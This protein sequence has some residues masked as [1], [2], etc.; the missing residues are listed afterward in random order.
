MS[1]APDLASLENPGEF[2]ARH[3]GISA[4]DEAHML[5]VIGEAS[6]HAL[7]E[8][9]VPRSIA[10]SAAMQLP[11]ATT[12]AAALA[13]LKTI[14]GKNKVYRSFI[15][16]G[17]YG[18][19]T[20]GVILRNILENPAWYTAYTPY[21]AEIS[22][23]RMEALVNFQ[24]MVTDLTGMAIANASML[25]EATA[26]AEAMTLAKR[27]V[28][29]KGHTIV[30]AGDAHPQTIE[31]IQT[32]AKPLGLSV[33]LAN[34]SQ[35]W[36]DALAAD[37][38]FAVLAQYPSTSGRIDDLRADVQTVHGKQ[39]AFI[40]AADL[41]ALTL[42]VPPGEFDA[43]IAIG[44]TQRF[45]MPMGAGGPHAA[46]MACR[47]EFKRSL[48]GRLVGVSVDTHG[49]PAYRLALQTR[50]QHI[51]REKATSNICTA[52]VLPAVVASM[53]AVYHGPQGLKRIAQRVAAYTAV[54][55]RGLQQLGCTLTSASAFDTLTV[56]A[57]DAAQAQG[58]VAK[59]LA[60]GAN[61]KLSWHQYVS[62]SLDETSTREDIALLWSV[63]AKDGQTLPTFD[64]FEKGVEPLIPAALRRTSAFLTHPVF[65]M[66]HSETGMLRYLRQLS[67]K[68]LA[69]D[70]SMIP[71]GSCTMKLNATSEMIPITWPEFA[72]VHPFAPADQ[73]AGYAEL[74]AQL[75][76]WL[77][78]ITG[79]AGVSLQPNAGSQGEYAGL[80]AIRA[81][82]A[83]RGD[84]Q[85][86]VCLIPSSA[87]GTNPASAQMAGLKVVVTKC[88]E[89]GNVDLADLKAK[90]E[91]YSQQLA[92]VMITYPS[93]HG[94][95]ETQVKDLCAL[96]HQHGG[97]VYVDGANMNALVGVAA[98]GEFG[99]DVSHL[100]LHKTFCIPHGGGGPGV[101]PVC[102]VEDLVPFLPGL[103][104]QGGEPLATPAGQVGP[105]SAA[106]LG[107]AAVLPISWMYVRM[108]GAA[109]L[110]HATEAAILSANYISKRLAPH[111]PTLYASAN[112]HVAHECILDL[113]QLKETSG[114]M[115]EDVAKRLAD[116]GFHAPTLS[117]P[118]ANTLMVEPT[119]SETREELDRFIDAM[120]AIR[121]EI[122]RIERGEWP[123]DDNPL[124]NAPH[125]AGSLL[126]ADWPHP[127]PREV[128]GALAGR[129][130]GSVKYWPPV[131]RVDNVYGDRNLFCSCVPVEE[132]A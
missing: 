115:A 94:V 126:A 29:S 124:K 76:Q 84:S 26:A 64:P 44:T 36:A 45:G 125:T 113:R 54:L 90:C 116:Y 20:P 118:V 12:E 82:H 23:G 74:D 16:Q 17:Y 121:E 70:R 111:Y 73:L 47:D 67:D 128:G 8:G 46:Y 75:R 127:Y 58:F 43:D 57:T 129:L 110:Q 106:P 63:F 18:T 39:A 92:A 51:R 9:I 5:S 1:Q 100:N 50:E 19:H 52:Q 10:R 7:I 35:E 3:I 101:G 77:C 107:N 14:A 61:L 41:L 112:G 119:E 49:N 85:R 32:R 131:G 4:A 6:R 103:P 120:I 66:H 83:S 88:D 34:S 89:Q 71:L 93:T 91:Q 98:P 123:Q 42:L 11:P 87:H 99:G 28:K 79:Y 105:V 109:G 65:N 53:Y 22:Q 48:P 25:D 27:S 2:I 104:G 15:G 96:V 86:D 78:A 122:R 108:M 60:K 97:R 55:A 114:V 59:A 13:E 130:P 37:D 38:Y 56:K 72:E 95:F 62:M 69:L 21:P 30:V 117:F 81:W 68:D 132:L 102:V 33:K 31:V 40:V 24:T 80:L